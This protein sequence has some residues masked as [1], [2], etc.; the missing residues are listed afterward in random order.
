M[1]VVVADIEVA[2][3]GNVLGVGVVVIVD[4]LAVVVHW[5]NPE[6]VH[7]NLRPNVEVDFP[8]MNPA[9]IL[10]LHQVQNL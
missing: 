7:S 4:E 3:A 1:A 5:T 6:S 2:A 9:C 8:Q 10:N